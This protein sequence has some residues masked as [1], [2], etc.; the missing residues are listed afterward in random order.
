MSRLSVLHFD[1]H[2][3][4][5]SNKGPGVLCPAKPPMP[6]ISSSSTENHVHVRFPKFKTRS[7]HVVPSRKRLK[8]VLEKRTRPH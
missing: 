4:M 2:H 7:V 1:P 8:P 5:P 6:H 3:V